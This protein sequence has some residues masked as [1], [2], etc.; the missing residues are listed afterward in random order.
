MAAAANSLHHQME[1]YMMRIFF[2]ALVSF[3]T[4][5]G[6]F[7]RVMVSFYVLRSFRFLRVRVEAGLRSRATFLRVRNV[8][9]A[10]VAFYAFAG[11]C[12]GSLFLR[13]R[14]V[15]TDLGA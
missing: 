8:R 1:R 13:V 6:R 9:R 4:R 12:V 10:R 7:L 14:I 3:F 11:L 2:Y 15:K 5:Y